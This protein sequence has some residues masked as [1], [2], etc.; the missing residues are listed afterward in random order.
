M[1]ATDATGSRFPVLALLLALCMF[2][3]V[4]RV[5]DRLPARAPAPAAAGPGALAPAA[6]A[7]CK[8]AMG[9]TMGYMLVLML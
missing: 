2:G 3:Y 9:L 4:V 6:P 8:V 7:L 1:T 5:A